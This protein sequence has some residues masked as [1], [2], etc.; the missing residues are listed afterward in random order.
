MTREPLDGTPVAEFQRIASPS[1]PVL[2]A[3]RESG[4]KAMRVTPAACAPAPAVVF[5]VA[6]S[7]K[8]TV[9]SGSP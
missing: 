5:P 3:V 2:T 4:E 8:C 1:S 7:K 9:P 6:T